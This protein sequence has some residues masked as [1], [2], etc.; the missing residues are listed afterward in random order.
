M[1]ARKAALTAAEHMTM[2][3]AKRD[4]E[5]FTSVYA[6]DAV[7]WHNVTRTPQSKA[8]NTAFLAATMQQFSSMAY[9]DIRRVFT[10]N[11]IVQQHILTATLMNGGT[12]EVAS[13]LVIEMRDGKIARIDEYFDSNPV[14]VD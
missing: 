4:A 7:V 8:E 14:A 5:L 1:N 2:A 11:G 6:D 9:K 13:C 10:E 3:M 12:I